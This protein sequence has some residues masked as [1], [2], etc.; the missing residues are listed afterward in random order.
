MTLAPVEAAYRVTI[1]N[2][3]DEVVLSDEDLQTAIQ[4][5]L[6]ENYTGILSNVEVE[7]MEVA[8]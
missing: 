2:S 4:G 6:E 5:Y 8:E 7:R 3:G 1:R